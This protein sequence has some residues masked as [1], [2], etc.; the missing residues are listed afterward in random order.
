MASA[1]LE[2]MRLAT[3][4]YSRLLS[5]VS[6]KH[7]IIGTAFKTIFDIDTNYIDTIFFKETFIAVHIAQ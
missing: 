7:G 6:C 1:D 2:R 4:T 5:A 3:P